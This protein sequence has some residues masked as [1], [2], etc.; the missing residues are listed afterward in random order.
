MADIPEVL[1]AGASIELWQYPRR[2]GALELC[3]RS[4]RTNNY[5]NPEQALELGEKLVEEAKKRMESESE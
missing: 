5:L 1:A 3:L 4:Y 2:D